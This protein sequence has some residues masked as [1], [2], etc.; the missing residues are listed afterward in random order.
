MLLLK[1]LSLMDK[2]SVKLSS[3]FK[4]KFQNMKTIFTSGAHEAVPILKRTTTETKSR[5]KPFIS[6]TP[7]P[8][9]K[10]KKRSLY[11]GEVLT[12]KG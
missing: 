10:I 7:L 1:P 12:L 8:K 5:T 9:L 6:H 11:C 3:T 4:S 2:M